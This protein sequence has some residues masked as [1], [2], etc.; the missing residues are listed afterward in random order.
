LE[1]YD[2]SFTKANTKTMV[3]SLLS[4]GLHEH[5]PLSSSTLLS[6]PLTSTLPLDHR[7]PALELP[8]PPEAAGRLLLL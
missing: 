4:H 2:S 1:S 3:D 7:S 8:L 5:D 6:F